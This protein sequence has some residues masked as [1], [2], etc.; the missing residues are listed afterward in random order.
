MT[1]APGCATTSPDPAV[2]AIDGTLPGGI[3]QHYQ[4]WSGNIQ[5]PE[6]GDFVTESTGA[7][8]PGAETRGTHAAPGLLG[9]LWN[10]QL[11][12]YPD[13][14]PRT[15]YLAITVLSTII[16]YYE[17]YIQGAVATQ[18]IATYGFT[19]TQFVLILVVGNAVGA[20]AS[21]FAGLADRWG[22]ANLVVIGLLLTGALI[23][24][25]LPNASSKLMYGVFFALL[26]LVEGVVLVATPALIR[27][28]SPQVGRGAAMGFWTLGPVLGSLVV[29]EVS[30]H[31]LASHPDWRFQF[32]LCG[33]VGLGVAVLAL[34]ALRELSPALRDQLMVSIRDRALIEAR[35]AGIDPEQALKNHWRQMLRGDIVGSA[36]AI[37]LYLLSYYM[38]VAFAVIFFATVYG[39]PEARANSLLN[40]YWIANAVALV[41]AGVVSDRFRVRKPFMLIGAV[42]S[43]IGVGL[44]AASST[45]LHVGYYTLAVYF[46]LAAGGGG[47]AYVA[48]MSAFTET[49]ERHNPAATATGLAVWGWILRMV[50]T[51]GFAV[52]IVAL[53]AT[54]TLV[55]KGTH[56]QQLATKYAAQVKTLNHVD[57]I[58]KTLLNNPK[59]Q[60]AQAQA[61]AEIAGRGVK[62]ADVAVVNDL[63]TNHAKVVAALQAI[64]PETAA[65]LQKTAIP[66]PAT[67]R[68]ALGQIS[69]KLGITRKEAMS[70]LVAA[71]AIPRTQLNVLQDKGPVIQKAVARLKAVSKIPKADLAYLAV[72]GPTVQKAQSENPSQWQRWWWVCFAGQALLLPALLLLTG[73]WSPRRARE[74]EAR[75]EEMVARELE[76]L[77][78]EAAT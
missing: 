25:A 23:A 22:R 30:S 34:I 72:N 59:D 50:V 46:I 27:D 47:L 32:Y 4:V 13:T 58:T 60:V 26:S 49:V 20:L 78:G 37:S 35:A 18:I 43:M 75:H 42:I 39:Y 51:A 57:P 24:F 65:A 53:P 19:F 62:L 29:T 76:H 10:R 8:P 7:I 9:R 74:E 66:D 64:D 68:T 73:R 36:L 12:H 63:V 69:A 71:A 41:V 17:L 14:G 77:H 3:F 70:R 11:A 54:S 21:L 31:T 2:D 33:G 16:L 15:F 6:T 52:L 40:W 5:P 1:R 44:F 55:D 56:T 28:F 45:D 61:V 67:L 48:W 38:L